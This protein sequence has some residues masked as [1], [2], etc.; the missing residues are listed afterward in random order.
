MLGFARRVA[1]FAVG[2]G[3]LLPATA[4]A[5]APGNTLPSAPSTP[6]D[7]SLVFSSATGNLVAVDDPD[8]GSLTVTVRAHNA[9]VKL[10]GTA[11][12]SFTGSEGCESNTSGFC[13]ALT[14]S[15]LIA[16]INAALDGLTY[17]P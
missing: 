17:R 12:L 14:L 4:S 15:G 11:G 1:A 6:E 16:D 9:K 7:T 5:G 10:D 3:L 8:G 2:A 13:T